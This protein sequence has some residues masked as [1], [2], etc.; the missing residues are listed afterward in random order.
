MVRVLGRFVKF[1]VVVVRSGGLLVI[2]VCNCRFLL[3][4]MMMRFWRVMNCRS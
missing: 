4:W 1:V 2:L 3:G